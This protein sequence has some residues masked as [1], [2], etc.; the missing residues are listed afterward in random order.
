M[1]FI[2]KPLSKARSTPLAL[3][4]IMAGQDSRKLSF[5]SLT[6]LVRRCHQSFSQSL[7]PSISQRLRRSTTSR[8]EKQVPNILTAPRSPPPRYQLI[9]ESSDPEFTTAP[10]ERIAA[11]PTDWQTSM[12]PKN[13]IL[14]GNSR[15]DENLARRDRNMSS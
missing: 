13:S 3:H 9:W 15:P 12:G 2:L 14:R 6:R 5:L 11:I 7:H 8:D 1:V 4:L 10:I